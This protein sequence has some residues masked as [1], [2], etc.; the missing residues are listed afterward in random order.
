MAK[1]MK[2]LLEQTRARIR[3]IGVGDAAA[4]S[5]GESDVLFLDVRES[6]ELA[7]GRI[8]GAL[9]VP[10]GLIEPKAA[11]D[12]PARETQLAN[13]DRPIIAYCASGVRS[14]LVADTLQVLGFS[15][16]RS[17]AGGFG[18]WKDGGQPIE[19]AA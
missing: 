14:A 15:D 16:V 4:L 11:H 13:F 6:E 10:R 19:G 9:H 5:S 1:G 2:E 17:L 3:E 18:A 8:P 12:S 7:G